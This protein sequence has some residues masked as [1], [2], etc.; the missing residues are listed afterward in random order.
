MAAVTADWLSN[1]TELNADT[2]NYT[3]KKCQQPSTN[4]RLGQ[5]CFTH[6][7]HI[8]KWL[9]H[10]SITFF[11]NVI[12]MAKNVIMLSLYTQQFDLITQILH[13]Q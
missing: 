8:S 12:Y 5:G 2:N 9:T 3:I 4:N 13:V 1:H 7:N 6:I 10:I 11:W